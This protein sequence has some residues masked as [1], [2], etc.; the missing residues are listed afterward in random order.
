MPAEI[1]AHAEYCN[2]EVSSAIPNEVD[3][4]SMLGV[5]ASMFLSY[6]L[7]KLIKDQNSFNSKKK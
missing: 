7:L 1:L 4:A 2:T 5:G 3:I 6:Q